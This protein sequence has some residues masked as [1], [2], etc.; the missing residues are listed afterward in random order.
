MNR[1]VTRR[2][3]ED[4]LARLRDAIDHLAIRTTMLV[5]FADETN[6]EFDE[7]LDFVRQQRFE[8]LG[9]FAYSPEPG[10]PA[11]QYPHQTPDKIK[12]QRYHQ[13]MQLQQDIAFAHAETMIGQ[14]VPCLLLRPLDPDEIKQLDLAPDQPWFLA[15]HHRQAPEIDAECYLQLP[16]DTNAIDIGLIHHATITQR[17]DYDL[18]AVLA[19]PSTV[20]R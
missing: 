18:V 19:K 15:R 4:L 14:T 17:L 3:T 11:A 6:A 8:A 12:Q 7:L 5:G 2:R 16:P 9:A 1:H 20:S 10:T 13:I